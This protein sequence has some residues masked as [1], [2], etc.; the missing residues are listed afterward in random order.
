MGARVVA[1]G[2]LSGGCVGDVRLATLDDGRAVVVK[3]GDGG[4]LACEGW[5]LRMLAERTALPAPK[6]LAESQGVLILEFANGESRFD[7]SAERHAAESLADLHA[8]TPGEFGARAD[9]HA[10]AT[11][12]ATAAADMTRRF[13]F[14]R[15]TVIG[16]LPQPNPWTASWVEFFREQ[17]L[18]HMGREAARAGRLPHATLA[19]LERFAARLGEFIHEPASPSLVH[20]DVWAGNVLARGG[21]INA[22]LDPSLH[23][24]HAEV[25]LAFITLFGTF[26]DAFFERY[27]ERRS[28]GSGFF[29]ARGRT[30]ARRDV[31]NLYPLLV[32]ARL[33]GGGYA[34]TV[35]ATLTRAGF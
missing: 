17:R 30:I 26:G 10:S 12:T 6:V 32:H 7:A 5:M 19:R 4:V 31:Y 20:G 18:L 34:E 23:F 8:I 11:V 15:D 14:E 29:E 25:E 35:G 2:P 16:G 3:S 1:S 21:R 22:F 27:A 33:F 9:P 13:G 28:I 24:A